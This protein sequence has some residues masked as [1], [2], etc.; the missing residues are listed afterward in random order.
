MEPMDRRRFIKLSLSAGAG[1]ALAG[2]PVEA[3]AGE[4]PDGERVDRL[5]AGGARVMWVA[6]HP[7]DE[8]LVGAILARASLHYRD[9]LYMLVLTRGDGGE[10]CRPEGCLPD[11]ATVRGAEMA[12]VADRYRAEL[13]LERFWNAP[14]PVESFPKRQEIAKRWAAFKDPMLVIAEAVRRFK[15]DVLFTFS[16][17]NG[18]TGHPEHQLA[19]RF[20]TSGVKEAAGDRDIGGMPPHK[21]EY[22]FYGLNRYWPF[23]L[24]NRADPGPV[25]DTFDLSL[26][27]AGRRTCAEVMAEISKC[28]RTQARDMGSVRKMK[29]WL[30][31]LYLRRADP[32]TDAPDPFEPA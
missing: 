4:K 14:L 11:L 26:P 12:D 6:A 9:P 5:L 20:A 21:V 10:C 32:F 23:R 7:D 29:Q 25:T 19:S 2:A 3:L 1:V 24:F 13:Q 16:P 18:F 15:P 27:C 8:A 17:V 31:V 22:V 28:H 30:E